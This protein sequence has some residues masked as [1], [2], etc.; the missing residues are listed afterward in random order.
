MHSPT[1]AHPPC[2]P[3]AHSEASQPATAPCMCLTSASLTTQVHGPSVFCLFMF[4]QPQAKATAGIHLAL[5]WFRSPSPSGSGAWWSHYVTGRGRGWVWALVTSA[6]GKD[7]CVHSMEDSAIM[8]MLANMLLP[9]TSLKRCLKF[10]IHVDKPRS[11]WENVI[12]TDERQL[13]LFG[14]F[15][16]CINST[17][18]DWKIQLWYYDN[19]ITM[20]KHDEALVMFWCCFA[21]AQRILSLWTQ[22]IL[23]TSQASRSE[24]Y[25]WVSGSSASVRGQVSLKKGPKNIWYK[26]LPVWAL[27]LIWSFWASVEGC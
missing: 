1:L 6:K 25:C 14:F 3:L 9:Y 19:I 24:T 11:C 21:V 22:W 4:W 13:E 8:Q 27:I 16:S 20:V 12:W 15:L 23:K 2:N 5:V 10:C 7:S 17:F 26:T 18:I